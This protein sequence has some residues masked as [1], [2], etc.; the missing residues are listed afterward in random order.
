[1]GIIPIA[2]GPIVDRSEGVA[3]GYIGLYKYGPLGKLNDVEPTAGLV[4]G[5]KSWQTEVLERYL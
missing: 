5:F 2:F 3:Q 4:M 1:M